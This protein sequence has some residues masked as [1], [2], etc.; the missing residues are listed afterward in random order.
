MHQMPMAEAMGFYPCPL[1]GQT[2]NRGAR[3]GLG[4]ELHCVRNRSE[5]SGSFLL[6]N[7][8]RVEC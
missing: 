6:E 7:F 3:F 8:L 4:L 5:R 1:Q 2:R